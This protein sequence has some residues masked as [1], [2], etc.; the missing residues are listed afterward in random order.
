[1]LPFIILASSSPR[2]QQL[3]RQIGATFTT[4]SP[5]IDE[6]ALDGELPADIVERLSL[7]KARAVTPGVSAGVVLGSDTIVTLGSE[8]LGKPADP[9]EARS[10][11]RRLSGHTHVVFTGFALLDID[12]G[13]EVVGHERT[14]V[15]FRA[16]EEE[17]I[18]RY[19]NGGSPMD[20]AGA[21]GIQ[22]DFGAVFIERI[23]GDYY[24]VV[25]LPLARVYVALR[26]LAQ[27]A[28]SGRT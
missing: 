16:L 24:T 11:L 10:M 4:I 3:L 21:Y 15:T 22:D 17:E 6:I 1:M 14:A 5:D 20:K 18:E 23:E 28:A 8:V 19:V 2:R 12:S 26:E 27:G 9:E 13:R 25:G 7:E